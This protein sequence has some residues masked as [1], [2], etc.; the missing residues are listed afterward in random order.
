M[1]ED[2]ALAIM[3]K[4]EESWSKNQEKVFFL[5]KRE[6]SV[7]SSNQVKGNRKSDP[8]EFLHQPLMA[9][10]DTQIETQPQIP[11]DNNNGF[12]RDGGSSVTQ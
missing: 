6:K 10:L 9:S 1:R 7:F 12:D 3:E 8:T 2:T 4:Q 11:G 5:K